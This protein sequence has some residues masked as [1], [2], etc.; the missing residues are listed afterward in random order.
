MNLSGSTIRFI[1]SG[2]FVP[3]AGDTF[4]FPLLITMQF[5]NG[6][7]GHASLRVDGA[8]HEVRLPVPSPVRQID[9]R[10]DLGLVPV[11]R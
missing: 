3:Q 5:R 8:V 6:Q 4:D 1:F 9:T 2:G 7:T 11:R 10:D